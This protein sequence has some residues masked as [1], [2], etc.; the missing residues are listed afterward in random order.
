MK[1]T[2]SKYFHNINDWSR[3]SRYPQRTLPHC[4]HLGKHW[5]SFG[6]WALSLIGLSPGSWQTGLGLVS[7]SRYSAQ[8]LIC[9]TAYIFL[10]YSALG[11]L[12]TLQHRHHAQCP[13]P[14][15]IEIGIS[16]VI[17]QSKLLAG[18]WKDSLAFMPQDW[19]NWLITWMKSVSMGSY[20]HKNQVNGEVFFAYLWVILLHFSPKCRL[21]PAVLELGHV[22]LFWKL[23]RSRILQLSRKLSN[24]SFRVFSKQF[25]IKIVNYEDG[26]VF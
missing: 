13:L 22:R 21:I 1:R 15:S 3:K 23:I 2:C 14:L 5:L 8:I 12:W 20:Q 6:P 25:S 19:W 11:L 7:M 26:M 4:F 9:F 17:R 18:P 16:L 24:W 10:L